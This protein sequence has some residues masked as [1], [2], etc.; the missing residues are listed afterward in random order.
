WGWPS[1]AR[2]PSPTAGRWWRS[3]PR[4]AAPASASCCPRW[5]VRS[6]VGEVGGRDELDRPD[7]LAHVV[8][9]EGLVELAPAAFEGDRAGE[10]L[11]DDELRLE[12]VLEQRLL[13]AYREAG[14]ERGVDLEAGL[15]EPALDLGGGLV[16]VQLRGA[17]GGPLGGVGHLHDG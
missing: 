2:S 15:G 12:G 9:Q 1:S 13:A 17:G 7:E 4:A 16:V 6:E 3:A 10:A 11:L 8:G 14:V 5:L